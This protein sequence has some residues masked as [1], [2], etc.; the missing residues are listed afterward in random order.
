MLITLIFG[1]FSNAQAPVQP[2]ELTSGHGAVPR[3]YFGLHIHH[4]W[5]DTGWPTIDFGTWRLWDAHVMWAYLEPSPGS[6]DFTLLDKYVAEAEKHHVEL[7]LTLAGTPAWASARPLEIPIHEGNIKGAPGLA[8]EPKSIGIW[9]DFVRT[10]GAR[11]RGRIRY[12][13]IWNEPMNKPF[14]SGSPETMVELAKS[15]SGV[16]KG[17][18]PTNQILSPPVSGDERGLSWLR[19]FLTAGGGRFIDI[20]GFHFYVG[21][22]PEKALGKVVQ[23]NSLLHSFGEDKKPIWNTETG[24]PLSRMNQDVA[25]SYVARALLLGWPSGLERYLY[26]SWEHAEMGIAPHGNGTTAMASAYS[27]VEEWIVGATVLRCGESASGLWMEDLKTPS[28]GAARIVW[29]VNGPQQLT[30]QQIGKATWFKALDGHAVQIKQGSPV[31]ANESPILL[32]S[33]N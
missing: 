20:Y 31:S 19:S 17:I 28:G 23:A 5:Q 15:A 1:T 6:Y 7:V 21:G 33:L 24:W 3:T 25:A 26:Y 13:E 14:Y 30:Q 12:Y 18:D 9:T 27:S 10:V 22:P 11:Y 8:A 16:L 32:Y 4:L 2:I 29:S